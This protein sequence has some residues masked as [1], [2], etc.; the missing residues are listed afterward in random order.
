MEPQGRRLFQGKPP[1]GGVSAERDGDGVG[2]H[3]LKDV[4]H[5]RDQGREYTSVA[6]GKCYGEAGVQ[7]SMGSVGDAYD[8]AMA[9]SFFST[10]SRVI[11]PTPVR[12]PGG[13]PHSLLQLH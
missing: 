3:R 4:I 12:R 11:E 6:F 5:H 1:A 8:N 2:Q 7:P 9:E 13:D 10:R